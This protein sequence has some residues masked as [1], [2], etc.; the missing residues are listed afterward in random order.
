MMRFMTAVSLLA[1]L[2]ACGDGQP[3]F[4]ADGNLLNDG[5]SSGGDGTGAGN[6]DGG[7][8]DGVDGDVDLPP[9]TANPS[10]SAGIVRFE[11]ENGIG[12]GYAQEFTY[13][14]ASDTFTVDNL[15]FDG[16]NVYQ[17]GAEIDTLGGYAV[18]DADV[19]TEDFLTGTEVNQVVPY[20][21]ILGLSEN[22]V[23][24]ERRTTFAIVRTG[25]YVDYG[26]GGFV[27]ERNGGTRLPNEGQAAF[28]GAYAGLRVYQN[29]G[30]LDYV[31]GDVELAIDFDDFNAN[32]AVKGVISDRQAFD[33]DGVQVQDLALPDLRFD[34]IEGTSVLN[35][36]GEISGTLSSYLDT[37][38]GELELYEEGTYYAIIAG[39]TTDPADGGEVVGVIV[40]ESDDRRY[41]DVMVQ[42]TGGFIV[43]R[44]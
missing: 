17:R 12:G 14:A 9:G 30:G 3:F 33:E 41:D 6:G 20:R 32:D 37:G 35:G 40:V 10:R 26:F 28:R 21:A 15:A 4:D 2:S 29:R 5:G 24:D 34:I 31:Q 23:D 36:T 1:L 44:N 7:D 11:A 25:G 27:Y 43:Y 39:D 18:F 22:A 38:T 13:D 8:G 42:E 19:V 16:E